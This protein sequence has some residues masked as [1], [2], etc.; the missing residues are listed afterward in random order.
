[1]EQKGKKMRV[2]LV[3]QAIPEEVSA[4]LIENPNEEQLELLKKANDTFINLDDDVEHALILMTAIEG[5][6]G[7][8]PLIG[9][10]WHS[11]WEKC[12]VKFPVEGPIDLVVT[13]G[14][15]C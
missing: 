8:D 5:E 14:Y 2:L 12:R 10:Q 3:W 7:V 1:M 6:D 4:Y 15:Y 9:A 13:S 11:I